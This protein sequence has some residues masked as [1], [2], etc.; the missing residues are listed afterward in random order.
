MRLSETLYYA[1]KLVIGTALG[2]VQTLARPM[3]FSSNFELKMKCKTF[4]E[5]NQLL[6]EVLYFLNEIGLNT[7]ASCKGHI[8][9]GGYIAFFLNE[10]N[11]EFVS[12]MCGYLLDNAAIRL[13]ISPYHYSVDGIS[14]C[15]YF[16]V[17]ERN[18][19]LRS[20]LTPALYDTSSTNKIVDEM[21]T[22][23]ELQNS[24]HSDMTYSLCLEKEDG[25]YN[26]DTDP[27][28]L[29]YSLKRYISV[30]GLEAI[31]VHLNDLD[32]EINEKSVAPIY[33]LRLLERANR[34]IKDIIC[35]DND[36]LRDYY[37]TFTEEEVVKIMTMSEIVPG[38]L[39]RIMYKLKNHIRLSDDE[40]DYYNMF[41]DSE[42]LYFSALRLEESL[43]Y[44]RQSITLQE[45]ERVL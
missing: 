13:Q 24:I 15:I 28:F 19:V 36:E 41:A 38:Q 29:M 42:D 17:K 23:S 40:K 8:N 22:L 43:M 44:K 18:N 32:D 1:R 2:R 34:S 9:K 26:V 20:M 39:E 5:G 3:D 35:S 31:C 10:A 6:S 27:L 12:K 45:E 14:V 25:A 11:K 30:A 4:S 7:F 21:I 37:P 33:L 16:P